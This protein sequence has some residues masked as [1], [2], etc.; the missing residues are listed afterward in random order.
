MTLGS[1]KDPREDSYFANEAKLKPHK[2]GRTTID[3]VFCLILPLIHSINLIDLDQT[4]VQVADPI[5][6]IDNRSCYSRL[7]DR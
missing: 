1:E 5:D 6:T 3:I 2:L 7:S 4:E